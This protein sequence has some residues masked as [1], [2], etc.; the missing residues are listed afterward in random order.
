MA[1][2]GSK[3]V[4]L[5]KQPASRAHPLTPIQDGMLFHWLM[6]RHS[7]NDVQQVIGDLNEWI[8]AEKFEQA[9]QQVLDSFCVL[10][11]VIRW[12]GLP[13]PLQEVRSGLKITLAHHDLRT[14]SAPIQDVRMQAYLEWDRREG[15]D[16]GTAPLWRVALFQ[17][18]DSHFRL[19]WSF[20]HVLMDGPSVEIILREVF[21]VYEAFRLGL[22]KAR[23]QD[24]AFG[25][26]VDW[27][28]G[29]DLA[30]LQNFWREK[31][32]GFTTP[33]PLVVDHKPDTSSVRLGRDEA[34][35]SEPSTSAL[36]KLAASRRV[37]LLTMILGVWAI[38]LHRYSD[39]Q[40]V[41]FGVAKAT[42]DGTIE[43]AKSMVG[44]FLATIP[45]R[46][47]I[48]PDMPVGDWLTRVNEEWG[49]LRGRE[50]LS[51]VEI[52]KATAV[53]PSASLFDSLV[54]WED[55][56]VGTSFRSKAGEFLNRRFHLIEQ[57]SY[58]LM[59]AA[60]DDAELP[61]RISYDATRFE[62]G[63]IRRMLGHVLSILEAI[64]SQP[65]AAVSRLPLLTVAERHQ[66]LVEW[67]DTAMEYP[68]QTPLATL[69]EE[70]VEQNPN[71]AAVVFA[72]ESITYA[73]L[74]ARANRL[75]HELR[76]R[77]VGPDVLVGVCAERSIGMIV[78]MLAVL[79]S[80]GA[81]VPLDPNFPRERLAYI[82]DDSGLRVLISDR[83]APVGSTY[84]RDLICLDD[85]ELVGNSPENPETQARPEHL[86]YVIYTSGTTGKPK[87]VQVSRASLTNFLWSIRNRLELKAEDTL[88]A[89]T[90]I[91]FDIAGL[92]IWLPLL[93]GARIIVA[94]RKAAGDGASLQELLSRHNVTA[95]QS[96]PVTWRLLLES[97]WRGKRDLLA[98]C[99]GEAL[100]RELATQLLALTGRLW[101][102]Y[103]PTETTIWSAGYLVQ[104]GDE[105]I[106]IGRPIGNTTCYILDKHLQPAPIGVTGELYIGGD[107][108]ARGYMNL[109]D[110]TAEK[111]VPDPFSGRPGSRMYRTG[112]LARFMPDGNI[113]CLGRADTQVKIRGFRIE[114]GAIEA[115]LEEHAGVKQ[116]VVVAREFLS[117][118][119]RL[120]GY[121]V[122]ATRM[123]D[124]PDLRNFLKQRLPEYMVPSEFVA[125]DRVPMT[126]NGKV[127]RRALPSPEWSAAES[128]S[129]MVAPRTALQRQL[130][131]LWA[132]A[133][134]VTKVGIR[135]NFF[136]LGGHSLL[137]ARLVGRISKVLGKQ[138]SPNVLFECPTIEEL[139][140][141]L[142]AEQKWFRSHALV[143]LQASGSKPPIYWIPGGAGIALF[144]LREVVMRLDPDQPVYGLGENR[145]ARFE[146]V[147][148]VSKRA[149]GYLELVRE[150]QP[151]GPYCF[152]GFCLGGLVAFDMAQRL[153]AKGEPV[154]FVGLVNAPV[155]GFPSSRIGKARFKAQRL[156]H[157]LRAARSWEAGILDYARQ[158]FAA[159][160]AAGHERS[161]VLEAER[162][163]R[164]R[165]FQEGL[166]IEDEVLLEVLLNAASDVMGSYVPKFYAGTITLFISEEEPLAGL[167]PDLDPR[168][169]WRRYAAQHEIKR[170]GGEHADLLRMP[171][172]AEFAEQLG[173]A[174]DAGVTAL[175]RLTISEQS[176]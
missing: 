121:L 3:P 75:A 85:A 97:G 18:A 6:D 23:P 30:G 135:D 2:L 99:G 12:E 157:H 77:G 1:S 49:S 56:F 131:D 175:K 133:F 153:R 167:S 78:A 8:D 130:A 24:R 48:D 40:D 9:W 148:D 146:D 155:P 114:L 162:K 26:Y 152:V 73:D 125:I 60:Y 128:Q 64:A 94:S 137:A 169:A 91:S 84:S 150:I 145:P 132:G 166:G 170:F 105:P 33:T 151:H 120:V 39:E 95:M 173:Q 47:A 21:G 112:D 176:L 104:A 76:K 20:H 111:F 89:V 165:G 158:R 42:R 86:A 17:T 118:D 70:R 124:R 134:D 103:G 43:G 88:L 164:Q 138:L 116:A 67:N 81:Y 126:S 63:T 15:F 62:R 87:G 163:I 161:L 19:V 28:G 4:D 147:D 14:V 100:P 50:H 106:L 22:P 35:L 129:T 74:N 110:L 160:R 115:V 16:L 34:R 36:R 82:I 117:G 41:V 174:V 172:A 143:T 27:L 71:N 154:A 141:S 119:K 168:C 31:L 61:V 72:E 5:P 102:L 142:E 65:D 38:L 109:P 144:S 93:V 98:V 159:R 92:E 101:N 108:V 59:L 29:I 127:D 96:T 53:P 11:T 122:P 140:I 32:K 69:I 51:L 90:T 139:A 52:K 83:R 55:D 57:S 44:Q 7:G 13:F 45:F 25:D 46:V 37:P 123:P 10:R 171:R 156:R 136:D 58:G 54:I 113:E 79:K 107:G 80:G 66:V 149:Q 68:R